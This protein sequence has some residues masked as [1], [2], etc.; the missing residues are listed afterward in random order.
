MC[1]LI[2]LQFFQA[3]SLYGEA[4]R[5]G[6]SPGACSQSV[7]VGR[8]LYLPSGHLCRVT[9]LFPFVAI[10]VLGQERIGRTASSDPA[11]LSLFHLDSAK[12]A[13]VACAWVLS[14]VPAFSALL[15]GE[16]LMGTC[17]L[18][19]LEPSFGHLLYG[20]LVVPS[21]CL[22]L[23]VESAATAAIVNAR[24]HDWSWV[25]DFTVPDIPAF[26]NGYPS[27]AHSVLRTFE[28]V[29]Y[30]GLVWASARLCAASPL[31]SRLDAA[32]LTS[33][34]SCFARF[35]CV[36]AAAIVLGLATQIKFSVDVTRSTQLVSVADSGR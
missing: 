8:R 17:P 23:R 4:S 16:C 36:L 21:H 33:A 34:P 28:Q 6:C 24:L 10:R 14:S 31:C 3:I 1:P 19:K 11:A 30:R 2:G 29:C 13:A 20:L 7:A 32:E 18:R 5:P 26:S 9:L 27:V 35:V 12:L 22:R 25:L 15:Y